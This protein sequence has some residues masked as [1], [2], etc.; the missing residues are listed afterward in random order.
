[1]EEVKQSL[2]QENV[3]ITEENV[4]K[5]GEIIALK[6]IKTVIVNAGK[7]LHWLYTGLLRDMNRAPDSSDRF[8]DG[9]DLAMTAIL[10]LCE[11]IGERLG[12]RYTT[13]QGKEITIK[14]ACFRYADRYLDR[15]YTRHISNTIAWDDNVPAFQLE[16]AEDNSDA[17]DTVIGQMK[18]TQAEQETLCAY[19][20]GM[21]FMEITRMLQVNH[22]TV[23]RRRMSIRQKYMAITGTN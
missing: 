16:E 10:F 8:S 15:Q 18:L 22:S 12:D 6:V 3:E 5:I 11:H 7:D 23:W 20:A 2:L 21:T 17:V 4:Q 1:M 14:R 13:R 19:M 9:Y